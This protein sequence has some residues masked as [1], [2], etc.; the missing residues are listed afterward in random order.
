MFRL[1]SAFAV[2]VAPVLLF[3]AVTIWTIL[4][5]ASATIIIKIIIC[6]ARL[7]NTYA[8]A[9]NVIPN[10]GLSAF[11]WQEAADAIV[12]VG[13]CIVSIWSGISNESRAIEVFAGQ[14]VGVWSVTPAR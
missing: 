2:S 11:F 8:V 1:A 12:T 10:V 14:A 7:L 5:D 4:T 13:H 3:S 6:S 9:I